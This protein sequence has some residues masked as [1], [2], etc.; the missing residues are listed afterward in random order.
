VSDLDSRPISSSARNSDWRV[1][2]LRAYFSRDSR[3]KR[4]PKMQGRSGLVQLLRTE[5][6]CSKVQRLGFLA[7]EAPIAITIHR[8]TAPVT[9]EAFGNA[10]PVN[11]TAPL[12]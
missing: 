4:S 2:V 11:S 5:Q 6:T 10:E 1:G 3:N 8:P 7:C 9:L 12:P